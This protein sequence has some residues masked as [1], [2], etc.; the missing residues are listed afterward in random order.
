MRHWY[1]FLLLHQQN[2]SIYLLLIT[3]TNSYLSK[4]IAHISIS[5]AIGITW[6]YTV[7]LPEIIIN[8]F[9]TWLKNYTM[10][11][12]YKCLSKRGVCFTGK[13]ILFFDKNSKFIDKDDAING[14]VSPWSYLPITLSKNSTWL[15]FIYSMLQL[16]P[17]SIY[18][19]L[20]LREGGTP[21]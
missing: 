19:I 18:T 17:S 1:T 21:S 6:H 4:Y 9:H 7:S 10:F 20:Q 8:I 13:G 12:P 5:W 11:F 16:K 3:C 2:T 15:N 14:T